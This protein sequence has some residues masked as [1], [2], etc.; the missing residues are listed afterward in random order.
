MM[1]ICIFGETTGVDQISYEKLIER[2]FLE[3]FRLNTPIIRKLGNI[4]I[5][6]KPNLLTQMP[7]LLGSITRK[8][9][10][11]KC[12]FIFIDADGEYPSVTNSEK[13]RVKT[14]IKKFK[15]DFVGEIIIGVPTRNIEAWLLGDTGNINTVTGLNIPMITSK[16][17]TISTPKEEFKKLYSKYR[18][19]NN[20]SNSLSYPELVN[21]LFSTTNLNTLKSNS[22]TFSTLLSELK[23]Y[24]NL[25]G[26][27]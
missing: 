5:R 16:V 25:S 6:G 22:I 11:L 27:I 7:Y 20:S 4:I 10:G 12:I 17:E 19:Q 21:K 2:V 15:E 26:S 18:R 24:L 1:E 3:Y 9:S 23:S 14:K 13:K 8:Y